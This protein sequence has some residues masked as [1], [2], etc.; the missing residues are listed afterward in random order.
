MFRHACRAVLGVAVALA[1]AL[2]AAAVITSTTTDSAGATTASDCSV[3]QATYDA[4]LSHQ[5]VV[6]HKLATA[7]HQLKRAKRALRH[8]VATGHVAK[9]HKLAKKVRKLKKKVARLKHSYSV[10]R[11]Q[12]S[13]AR[14][15]LE[16]C[17]AS[18]PTTPTSPSTTKP[19]T[20]TTTKPTT[21][22]TTPAGPLPI[23]ALCDAGLP[24]AVCD[25]LAR[26]AGG[27]LPSDISL[28]AL[29]TAV[30]QFQTICDAAG[31]GTLPTDPTALTAL[32][33]PILDLLGLG[34]LLGGGLLPSDL[35]SVQALCDAGAPQEV[36][37]ALAGLAGG[38][39]DG[40]TLAALCSAAPQAQPLCDLVDGGGTL[41]TDP[42]ALADLLTPVLQALGLDA[43]LDQLLCGLLGGVLCL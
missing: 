2:A 40:V 7:R 22:T 24:Q 16:T 5:Q 26:L 27:G 6:K 18:T 10:A 31:G 19:T 32:L 8:A 36:C 33:Q 30:P 4:A 1:L 43:L 25:A 23:Q 20:P 39:P 17:L 28:D 35:T 12:T 37:D 29:C 14:S 13:T 34:D 15:A 41:P 11:D 3:Q 9:A 21:P 42:Q 38:T